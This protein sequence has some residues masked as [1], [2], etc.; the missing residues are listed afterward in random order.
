MIQQNTSSK[1]LF[2]LQSLFDFIHMD[3]ILKKANFVKGGI[4]AILLLKA[5]LAIKIVGCK[6]IYEFSKSRLNKI[7]GYDD[8]TYYRFMENENFNWRELQLRLAA[9]V[10]NFVQKTFGSVRRRPAFIV[11]DTMLHRLRSK[12]VEFLT[13]LHDHVV[14]KTLKG[15]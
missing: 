5:V 7:D 12:K 14:H 11:D 10:I 9:F 8:N 13:R 3:K 6:N 2:S 4:P 15:L 1:Q